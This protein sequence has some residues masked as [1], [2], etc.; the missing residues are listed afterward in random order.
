VEILTG[1]NLTRALYQHGQNLQ[2]LVRQSNANSV[3]GELP[4]L[5]IKLEKAEPNRAILWR[6]RHH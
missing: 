5:G 4:G 1:N 2:R 3:L 6:D